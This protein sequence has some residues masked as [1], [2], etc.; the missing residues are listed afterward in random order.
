MKQAIETLWPQE[1]VEAIIAAAS[2]VLA[3][4]GVEV[5]SPAARESLVESG[6]RLSTKGRVLMPGPVVAAA[7]AAC[8]A[9][10]RLLAR[11][12]ERSVT[13]DPGPGAIVTHNSGE[14]P[15]IGTAFDAATRPA[16]IRDQ[17]RAARVMHRLDHPHSVNSLFWPQDVPP[18]LQPLYSFLVLAGET[19]K[20][21]G[22]PCVDEA[23]QAEAL[24]E[25]ASAVTSGAGEGYA[26]D[27]SFSPVSPLHL[28]RE[29]CDGLTASAKAGAVC[30]ILPAPVAGTTAPA[31]LSAALAQQDAEVLAGVVLVQATR[32]GTPCYYG[33]RLS[34]A[35]PRTGEP[36]GGAA[37]SIASIGATLLAR[38]HGLACDCYGPHTGA[39]TLDMQAG[40]EHALGAALGALA[41]PRLLSGSGSFRSTSSCLE[42]L[43]LDDQV[44]RSALDGL[45]PRRWDPQALDV[46][47]IAAA[48]ATGGGYLGLAHTR[49]FLR[50]EHRPPTVSYRGGLAQWLDGGGL[51]VV[52]RAR[53]RVEELLA[54]APVGLPDGVEAELCR[55][56]DAAAAELG[57]DEWPDPR[58]VL[59]E[60][61]APD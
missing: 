55:R 20:H 36:I 22:S 10:F 11:D 38:R 21:L 27:V 40:Y 1:A 26:L 25:M 12:P 24:A 53:E 3:R 4:V 19:D 45:T 46:E 6:C 15:E 29:V 37:E 13:I 50:E 31:A 58:R 14:V 48:V 41:R 33:A 43:V 56:I 60:V 39:M 9:E 2:Q 32:P 7:L 57:L 35:D 16:T 42:L 61:R 52:E 5:D 44:F 30:E 54:H 8:P 23:W 51:D 59:E 34:T 28:G 49:V 17:A 47:A 18:R